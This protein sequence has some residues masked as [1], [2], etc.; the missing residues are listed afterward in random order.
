M[1]NV[2]A[3]ELVSAV[4]KNTQSA[5]KYIPNLKVKR[6]K[7]NWSGYTASTRWQ[8]NH[9]NELISEINFPPIKANAKITNYLTEVYTG[10]ALHE[11]GHNICTDKDTWDDAIKLEWKGHKGIV[12]MLNALEDPRQEKDLL[13][14]CHFDG[15]KNVLEKLTSWAVEESVKNGFKANDPRNFL[16]TLNTLAYIDWCGYKVPS[17][18]SSEDLLVASGKLRNDLEQALIKL[19]TCKNTRDVLNLCIELSSKYSS[20]QQPQFDTNGN[21]STESS[22]DKDYENQS[23][24]SNSENSNE[25]EDKDKSDMSDGSDDANGSDDA[26][27]SDDTDGSDDADG[28]DADGSDADGSDDADADADGS[29]DVS[30]TSN[31]TVEMDRDGSNASEEQ[32]S[33]AIDLTDQDFKNKE[34]FIADENQKDKGKRTDKGDRKNLQAKNY[35]VDNMISPNDPHLKSSI[36]KKSKKVGRE[37]AKINVSDCSQ[38]LSRI[39]RN[40]DRYGTKRNRDRGKLDARKLGK[41]CTN[42]P[43][44]FHQPWRQTGTRTVVSFLID[45][46]SSMRDYNND[47][48]SVNLALILGNALHKVQVKYSVGCFPYAQYYNN[49]NLSQSG[50]SYSSHDLYLLKDHDQNWMKAKDHVAYQ[51]GN[52]SGGTPTHSAMIAE[53]ERLAKRS[54]DRKVMI[55]IT[56]GLPNSIEKCQ[57][58]RDIVSKWGIEVIGMILCPYKLYPR[59]MLNDNQIAEFDAFIKGFDGCFDHFII[60]GS[61]KKMITHGLKELNKILI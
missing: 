29:D 26:D 50:E 2:I 8:Y 33:I 14:R 40:P 56:D 37:L 11:I 52:S 47:K 7:I 35:S 34:D 42:T 12:K 41:L 13:S 58:A 20:P 32:G 18:G 53:G 28:S 48:Q 49:Q 54:E 10:F 60:E 5:L 43:N 46:S 57:Q 59:E 21:G 1:H 38:T 17:V 9:E 55:I 61:A 25:F 30:G 24:S 23:T 39:L 45:T 15:A 4:E 44:I 6:L 22:E 31:S 19:K 36:D 51:Y 3:Q 27:G 16:F